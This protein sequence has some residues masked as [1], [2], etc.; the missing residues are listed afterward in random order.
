MVTAFSRFDLEEIVVATP[1]PSGPPRLRMMR[2]LDLDEHPTHDWRDHLLALGL[3]A[4]FCTVALI[5][6]L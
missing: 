3:M 4:L 1:S 6:S 2:P 5:L